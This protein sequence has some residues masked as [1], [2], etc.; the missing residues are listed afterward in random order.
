MSD[1][2][3]FSDRIMVAARRL[4]DRCIELRVKVVTAESCTGGLIAAALT[5]IPGSSQ[6]VERGLIVYSNDAKEQLLDVPRHLI[7]QFGA[8][9]EP[10]AIAM[11]TGALRASNGLSQLSIA[12]TGIAG[13][14][15]TITKP[16][17]LVHIA[18]SHQN[19]ENPL[20]EKREFGSIGRNQVRE[21]TVLAALELAVKCLDDC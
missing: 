19:R 15:G 12:V 2:I 9:S 4:M 6:F 14:G 7:E 8:V 13:P 20:H 11:A 10:V 21:A 17:G 18:V 5:E 16:E 1:V 3:I